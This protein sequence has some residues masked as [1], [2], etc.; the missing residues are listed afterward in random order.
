[1]FGEKPS[2][3]HGVRRVA[4]PAGGFEMSSTMV[5]SLENLILVESRRFSSNDSLS[6][7]FMSHEILQHKL[8]SKEKTVYKS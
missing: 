5:V 7:P 3:G 6:G 1:M 8:A 4:A 2:T